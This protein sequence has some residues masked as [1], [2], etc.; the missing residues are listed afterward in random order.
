MH[1]T[2]T[3][4]VK[5]KYAS[6]AITRFYTS[7]HIE[8]DS[9]YGIMLPGAEPVKYAARAPVFC[10]LFYTSSVRPFKAYSPVL[11]QTSALSERKGVVYLSPIPVV[12]I[13]RP[14]LVNV[15]GSGMLPAPFPISFGS[16]KFNIIKHTETRA[17]TSVEALATLEEGYLAYRTKTLSFEECFSLRLSLCLQKKRSS[18]L[19]H[20]A[21]S[22]STVFVYKA[23]QLLH[24]M[25]C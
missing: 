18:L 14:V 19:K 23:F 21:P 20:R 7:N 17:L 15:L 11:A 4:I 9:P 2:K 1:F 5:H 6:R 25:L 10:R 22:S 3:R 8:I 24:A 13:A 16:G 12:K